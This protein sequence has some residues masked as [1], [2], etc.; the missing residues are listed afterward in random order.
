MVRPLVVSIV[1]VTACSSGSGES[2]HG[3]Q[4]GV[5]DAT[6]G[7]S[8]TPGTTQ[9]FGVD[10]MTP[11]G[12]T[13]ATLLGYVS[14]HPY[15]T[16][17]WGT[18]GAGQDVTVSPAGTT[19]LTIDVT[20]MVSGITYWRPGGQLCGQASLAIPAAVHFVTADGGFDETWQTTLRS[21]DG[22]TLEFDEDLQGM[23]LAGTFH[24][25]YTGTQKWDSMDTMLT[26]RF[27]ADGARGDVQYFTEMTVA[28][29]PNSGSGGGLVVKAAS[30]VPQHGGVDS[31]VA[32][33]GG[34]GDGET[35]AQGGD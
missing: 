2:T 26:T 16:L 29:G 32:E 28:T 35:A 12:V 25:T 19:T 30:W 27:G 7:G 20:P 11:L 5:L 1:L 4:S 33:E 23:P 22:Q 8:C 14:D 6:L 21:T 9:T 17:T 18:P 10:D 3:G 24:V 34:A 15:A 31:G 13:P